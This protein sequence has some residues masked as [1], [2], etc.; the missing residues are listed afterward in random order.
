MYKDEIKELYELKK[1]SK[2]IVVKELLSMYLEFKNKETFI[3]K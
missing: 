3:I 1:E 2:K